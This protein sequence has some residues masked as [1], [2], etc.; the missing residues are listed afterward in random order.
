MFDWIE[1]FVDLTEGLPSPKEF[2]LFAAIN[3]ISSTLERK[4]WTETDGGQLFPNLY[5]ILAGLPASGKSLAVSQ[6]RNSIASIQGLHLGPDNPSDASFIDALASSAKSATNGSGLV[7]HS[8]MTVLCREFGVL[9]PT[10]NPSFFSTLGDIYDNPLSYIAPRRTSKSVNIESPT[11]NI[12]AAATPAAL[13][14]FPDSAWGEGFTSRVLFIYG[15][16]PERY[17]NMFAKRKNVDF[18]PLKKRLEEIYNEI[19][20]EFEWE[21]SAQEALRHWFNIEK[22][23]PIPTY[24]RLVNY[25]GRRSDHSMKLSMISAVSANHG[26]SVTESDFRRAQK[27]L[28]D[29]EKKM[30]DVF[31]AMSQKSDSQIIQDLHHWMYVEYSKVSRELRVPVPHTRVVRFLEDKVTSEKIEKMIKTLE[32]SGRIRRTTFGGEWVPNPL[33]STMEP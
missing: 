27:W 25:L 26:L 18:N 10:Y 28:F 17:R 29:A 24:G 1:T 8:A 31:R 14:A 3:S 5:T 2:R 9:I 19:H 16:A 6:S 32:S 12:L 30:P 11:L 33:T 21:D 22:M 20:G 23:H 4:V 13:G 7:I 15:S